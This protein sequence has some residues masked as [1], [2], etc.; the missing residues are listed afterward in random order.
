MPSKKGD[1]TSR[2]KKPKVEKI[3]QYRA[4]S[5]DGKIQVMAKTEKEALKLLKEYGNKEKKD[6]NDEK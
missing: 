2:D 1:T 4:T 6:S 3:V 5:A